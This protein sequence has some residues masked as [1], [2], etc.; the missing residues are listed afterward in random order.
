MAWTGLH[1]NALLMTTRHTVLKPG[2]RRREMF[3][4]A[5]RRESYQAGFSKSQ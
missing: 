3:L 4:E 1:N 2:V 5:G